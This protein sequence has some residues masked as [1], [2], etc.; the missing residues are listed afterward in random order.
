MKRV[1]TGL[2]LASACAAPE[3]AAPELPR[4]PNDGGEGAMLA[5]VDGQR[6]EVAC[7]VRDG[8]AMWQSDLDLAL[9]PRQGYGPSSSPTWTRRRRLRVCPSHLAIRSL[10]QIT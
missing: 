1:F 6:I 2:L 7:A 5:R 3:A 4:A 9:L 10:L 8:H